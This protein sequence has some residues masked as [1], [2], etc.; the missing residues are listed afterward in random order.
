MSVKV[1][2][3]FLLVVGAYKLAIYCPDW[4]ELFTF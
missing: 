1:S 3:V 2:V 4:L